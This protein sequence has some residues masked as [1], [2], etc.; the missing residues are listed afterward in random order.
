MLINNIVAA[1]KD[2]YA[3]EVIKEYQHVMSFTLTGLEKHKQLK[4]S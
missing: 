2:G 1:V 4:Q 3:R